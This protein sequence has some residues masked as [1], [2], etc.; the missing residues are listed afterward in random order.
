MP[1]EMFPRD[2]L[3]KMLC[4][5]SEQVAEA[6]LVYTPFIAVDEYPSKSDD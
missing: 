2:F 1:M 3:V 6:F 4:K 5:S